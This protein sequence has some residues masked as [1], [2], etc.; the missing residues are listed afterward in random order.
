MDLMKSG[1]SLSKPAYT[2][3]SCMSLNGQLF[4]FFQSTRGLR[5]SDPI[6][7]M[8]FINFEEPLSRGLQKLVTIGQVS[9][10]RVPN[11]CPHIEHLLCR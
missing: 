4:G 3:T 2:I 10:Y 6:S 8:M 11:P 9:P 5:Q 7:S 1:S